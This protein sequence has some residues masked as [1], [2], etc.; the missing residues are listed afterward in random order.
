MLYAVKIIYKYTNKN[1]LG[2]YDLTNSNSN[3]TEW[4]WLWTN[5]MFNQYYYNVKDFKDNPFEL[6]LDVS[7]DYYSQTTINKD[8]SK[9]SDVTE[10]SKDYERLG[11][12]KQN[13]TGNIKTSLHL[14]LE[15]SFNTF[16]LNGT[17]GVYNNIKI[18]VDIPVKNKILY[19]FYYKKYQTLLINYPKT[20][21]MKYLYHRYRRLEYQFR[22][23]GVKMY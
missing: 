7:A 20:S 15:N 21:H 10:N 6:Q 3:K 4:R 14:G 8:T 16:N 22:I 18:R 2:E 17:S 23:W 13:L 9:R 19:P 1:V 12:I 11:V 5:T